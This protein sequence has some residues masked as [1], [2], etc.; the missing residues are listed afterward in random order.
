MAAAQVHF[1]QASGVRPCTIGGAPR[2]CLRAAPDERYHDVA[3]SA[4]PVGMAQAMRLGPPRALYCS[5]SNQHVPPTILHTRS[6][7]Q[8]M[9]AIHKEL[10]PPLLRGGV[11][12]LGHRQLPPVV[13]PVTILC[14][15]H[16]IQ[17]AGTWGRRTHTVAEVAPH[18]RPITQASGTLREATTIQRSLVCSSCNCAP[19][20]CPATAPPHPA[21]CQYQHTSEQRG[22]AL[23]AYAGA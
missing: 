17:V 19:S 6:C 16:H 1:W 20:G 14:T 18:K 10:A 5:C 15:S 22:A 12:V 13:C 8:A 2:V 4:C 23:P 21:P 3:K 9:P 7:T 11:G